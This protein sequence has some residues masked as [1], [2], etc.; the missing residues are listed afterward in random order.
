MN[1][2]KVI[3]LIATPGAILLFL[4][5]V[6][7]NYQHIIGQGSEI[8]PTWLIYIFIYTILSFFVWLISFL[9]S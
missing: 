6:Y 1:K 7:A 3:N 8:V 5:S 4:F 2:V 9:N